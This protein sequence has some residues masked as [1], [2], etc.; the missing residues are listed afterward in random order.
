[1]RLKCLFIYLFIYFFLLISQ[2]CSTNRRE[3][4]AVTGKRRRV[5][6]IHRVKLMATI[7]PIT[8]VPRA[9]SE[10]STDTLP[11]LESLLR[12]LPIDDIPDSAEVL[13]LAVLVLQTR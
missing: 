8:C 11:L 6:E 7:R 4:E 9:D 13:G 12:S 1:M 2:S 5:N 3:T 10:Y